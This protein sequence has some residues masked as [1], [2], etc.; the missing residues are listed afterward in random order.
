MAP[1]RGVLSIPPSPPSRKGYPSLPYTEE[2]EGRVRE[3]LF[4]NGG[5]SSQSFS[6]LSLEEE[7]TEGMVVPGE[8]R[9]STWG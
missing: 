3:L 5:T 6:F 2:R 4:E 9:K 1:W 7:M 8:V